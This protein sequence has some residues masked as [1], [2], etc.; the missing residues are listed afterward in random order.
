MQLLL[1]KDHW[2]I[3]KWFTKYIVHFCFAQE[4]EDPP[5]RHLHFINSVV[6]PP[7]PPRAWGGHRCI[8][9]AL[10]LHV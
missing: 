8:T 7:P 1:N 10:V 6:S 3:D 9:A 5:L 4:S 2:H